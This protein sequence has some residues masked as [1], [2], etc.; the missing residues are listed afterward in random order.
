M[1]SETPYL[2]VQVSAGSSEEAWAIA[3]TSIARKL[4]ACAQIFP[5]R[6]CYEWEGSVVQDDEYLVLLKTRTDAYDRLAD[7]IQ[8]LHSYEVPEVIA[9]PL[10]RGSESYLRWIDEVVGKTTP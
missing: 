8:E 4:A 10:T 1:N 2:V 3:Q 7:C 5:I 9:L 6:S